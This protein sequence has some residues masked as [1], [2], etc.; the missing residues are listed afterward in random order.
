MQNHEFTE[1]DWK[2]FRTKLMQWQEAY[3]AKLVVKYTKLLNGNGTL[4]E[5]IYE[6]ERRIQD[7]RKRSGVQLPFRMS[8]SMMIPNLCFLLK[9]RVIGADD[10]KDFSD[11]LK[12]QIC[13]VT[14]TE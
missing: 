5:K 13:F 7:E 4:S 14:E 9:N 6:L 8:R 12:E 11:E 2:L 3:Y 10:L 1:N